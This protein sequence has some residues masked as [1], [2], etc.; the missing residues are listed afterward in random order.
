MRKAMKLVLAAALVISFA[1]ALEAQELK[2]PKITPLEKQTKEQQDKD[3]WECEDIARQKTGI[4]PVVLEMQM[5][6]QNSMLSQ[7]AMPVSLGGKNIDR[8]DTTPS[9]SKQKEAK[10]IQAK[11]K[12]INE[13]YKVY[14]KVFSE[15]MVAR[16]YKVK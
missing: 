15:E 6:T 14:L 4:D 1:G 10:S 12:E 13:S 2:Q 11:V 9:P 16:G 5:R 7:A 3:T 8:F